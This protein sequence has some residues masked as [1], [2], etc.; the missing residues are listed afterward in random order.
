MGDELSDNRCAP[1]RTIRTLRDCLHSSIPLHTA[2]RAAAPVLSPM[3]LLGVLAPQFA[4]G[5]GV[6]L[7]AV[8]CQR[9]TSAGELVF[10][11]WVSA[12]MLGYAQ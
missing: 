4:T 5:S 10:S 11:R 6:G 8:R 12:G 7:E 3:S 1:R 2:V 9:D